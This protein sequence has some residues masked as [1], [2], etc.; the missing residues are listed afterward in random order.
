MPRRVDKKAHPTDPRVPMSPV[1]TRIQQNLSGF[2]KKNATIAMDWYLDFKGV[3]S[4]IAG[5]QADAVI[6]AKTC[7]LPKINYF[8]QGIR[9]L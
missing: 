6:R 8:G 1:K 2:V 4:D 7:V 9:G 3:F 5:P